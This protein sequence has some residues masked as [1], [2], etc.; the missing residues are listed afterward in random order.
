MEENKYIESFTDLQVQ[1]G[2]LL[3]QIET[4]DIENIQ[5][6]YLSF[7]DNFLVLVDQIIKDAGN[8]LIF[9]KNLLPS[10]AESF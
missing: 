7:L 6:S 3:S 5:T 4:E 9:T 10:S 8:T 2:I 1:M